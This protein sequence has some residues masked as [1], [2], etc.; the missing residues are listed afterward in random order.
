MQ[1]SILQ[2]N[3]WYKEDI[4]NIISFIKAVNPDIA[5]L[6]ELSINNPS[7]PTNN[8]VT[9][10]AEKLGYNSVHKELDLGKGK[11]AIAN[12]IFS[13]HHL[14]NERFVM[15]NE[16]TGTGKFD[17][18]WRAYIESSVMIKGKQLKIGTVHMSYTHAFQNTPRKL[19]ETDNLVGAIKANKGSFIITGDFNAVP[20]SKVIEKIEQT[21]LKNCGPDY[22]ENSWDTKPFDYNGFSADSLDWRLDYAF[23][24]PDIQV[25]SAEILKTNFSDHLPLLI[26]I[27]L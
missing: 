18:E 11:I 24:T 19:Q 1:L 5:C 26:K 16:P 22:S 25:E 2:W 4:N 6:Q 17:D 21:G 14:A 15:I 9:Y 13:R 7:Q 23:A 3:I 10:V 8:T 27:N 20:G 12:G